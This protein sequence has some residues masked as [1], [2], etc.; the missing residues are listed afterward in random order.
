MR[1]CKQRRARPAAAR[2]ASPTHRVLRP[3]TLP[4]RGPSTITEPPRIVRAPSTSCVTSWQLI[5]LLRPIAEAATIRPEKS[6]NGARTP[7]L[8]N[9]GGSSRGGGV[10]AVAALSSP[11]AE[12]AARIGNCLSQS[13]AARSWRAISRF[14]ACCESQRPA[15]LLVQVTNSTRRARARRRRAR[16]SGRA[17]PSRP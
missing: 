2:S 4:H 14:R 16:R 11:P 12:K 10:A 7:A 1:R 9:K 5:P 15:G 3:H 17:K 6:G 8:R 13:Q